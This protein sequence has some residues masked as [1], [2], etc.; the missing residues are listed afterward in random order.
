[1]PAI[2]VE[3]LG[4]RF[5]DQAALRGVSLRIQPGERVALLGASGR[6]A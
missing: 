6:S 5:G 4:K 2:E 1:V 3:S